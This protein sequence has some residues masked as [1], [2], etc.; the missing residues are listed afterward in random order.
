MHGTS[1]IT[2]DQVSKSYGAQAALRGLGFSVQP[3]EWV[4]LLGPNGAGKT[5][6]LR[7][8]VGRGAAD[9]GT[10]RLFGRPVQ[11]G[12]CQSCLGLVPQEIALYPDLSARENLQF[13]G[14]LAGV[15]GSDL[16]KQVAWAL[17]W[18]G[19]ADRAGQL[20]GG[21][22]GGMKRRLNLAAGV[23]HR[24][25]VVLLDEP[26]VGV[27]PQSRER[28]FAMLRELHEQGTTLLLTTH[29]LDDAQ[30]YCDR[31]IIMDH[32]QVIA[33]GTLEELIE[34]TLGS[35]RQVVFTLDWPVEE[36]IPGLLTRTGSR[37]ARAAVDDLNHDLPSLMAKV[38]RAGYGIE[39]LKIDTPNL[40]HVFL[41]LTGKDLRE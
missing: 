41:H 10:I 6:L 28:L 33:A 3:G 2:V 29:H 32:G 26:T 22:S 19:L 24:P 36:P 12:K 39:D 25:A 5:T 31:L 7:L 9:Q 15:R 8:L 23:L 16:A 18:T 1:A 40:Q 38:H 14:R 37:L 13:F 30:R 34:T 20:V 11:A 17:D 35:Q 4:A 27:D 21:F